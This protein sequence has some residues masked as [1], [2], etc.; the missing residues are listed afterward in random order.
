MGFE[1]AQKLV[2]YCIIANE[3][4]EPRGGADEA[5]EHRAIYENWR[6]ILN[7]FVTDFFPYLGVSNTPYLG[8]AVTLLA[9]VPRGSSSRHCEN[10]TQLFFELSLQSSPDKDTPPTHEFA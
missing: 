7:F 5:A 4:A 1:F 9:F 2:S 3:V 6:K 8:I 10:M